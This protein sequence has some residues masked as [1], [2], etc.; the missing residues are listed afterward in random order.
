MIVLI[1]I[2]AHSISAQ[3]SK[4]IQ[5]FKFTSD[6]NGRISKLYSITID[7]EESDVDSLYISKYGYV[8]NNSQITFLTNDSVIEIRSKDKKHLLQRLKVNNP[9]LLQG[10]RTI[11]LPQPNDFPTN[12]RQE[13]IDDINKFEEI[14]EKGLNRTWPFGVLPLESNKTKF[15]ITPFIDLPNPRN[16]PTKGQLSL[17]ISFPFI[18]NNKTTVRFFFIA[19]ENKTHSPIYRPAGKEIIELAK[20]FIDE[21]IKS[22]L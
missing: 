13:T 22:M 21:I 5:T 19:R 9:T 10:T 16:S 1:L 17:M 11:D 12:Y 6:Y 15:K 20:G 18:E 3:N 2:L 4:I 7:L 8:E 14:L